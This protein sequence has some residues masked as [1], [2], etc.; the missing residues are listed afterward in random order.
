MAVAAVI[1][2]AG[3]STRFGSQ[4]QLARLGD[5]TMLER[6]VELAEAVGLRPV[7]V[8]VGPAIDPPSGVVR[9]ENDQPTAGLSRSL[10]LGIAAVPP[11]ARAAVVLLGDQPTVEPSVIRSLIAAATPARPVVAVRAQG[12]IGPPV[13]LRR[14]AFAMVEEA[15]GD[16]GLAPVIARHPEEV[17]YVD[18]AAHPPDVDRPADLAALQTPESLGRDG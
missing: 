12:R 7:I 8:V 9:V 17:A 11:G 3:S 4:K 10:Q 15:S 13:L 14:E 1:L 2:A 18:L 6:V 16:Q 5:H